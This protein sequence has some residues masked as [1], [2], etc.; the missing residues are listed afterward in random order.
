MRMYN[1]Q[2]Q[3]FSKK[4]VTFSFCSKTDQNI[5]VNSNRVTFHLFFLVLYFFVFSIDFFSAY[6]SYHSWKNERYKT[7]YAIIPYNQIF[8]QGGFSLFEHDFTELAPFQCCIIMYVF[9]T[10]FA[11]D[12][13][14]EIKVTAKGKKVIF[15]IYI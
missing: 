12:Q 3:I 10:P 1:V 13:E 4:Y 5:A 11:R 15:M 6:F 8:V 14:K 7:A 9:I 2:Y